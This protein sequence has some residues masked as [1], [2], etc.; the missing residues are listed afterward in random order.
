MERKL[1]HA[2][3]LTWQRDY[4]GATI[5]NAV[6]HA[7]RTGQRIDGDVIGA[8]GESPVH[9]NYSVLMD[10]AWRVQSCVIETYVDGNIRRRILSARGN[11]WFIDG[12]HLPALDG[13]EVIDLGITPSTNTIAINRLSLPIGGAGTVHAAYVDFPSLE[14]SRSHQSYARK[15][16]ARYEYHNLDSGFTAILQVDGSNTV[17]EYGSVWRRLALAE[18]KQVP[19]LTDGRVRQFCTALASENPSTEL[20][21][22][23]SDLDWLVGGW[24]AE[25]RDLQD[26]GS[27]A[28]SSGEWWFSWILEGRALQDVWMVPPPGKRS[29]ALRLN[30]RYGTT[31]R[32]FDSK[33]GRWHIAW[34]NPVSGAH[35]ELSGANVGDRIVLE[36]IADGAPIRWSFVDITAVS[37]RWMGE[38]QTA[39]G[40]RLESEFVLQRLL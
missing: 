10:D 40:W 35:N 24:H 22:H 34:I 1:P 15:D 37:F 2:A 4:R 31:T 20:E 39:D 38:R 9:A 23:A 12:A 18:A 8:I 6:V 19:V 25:V 29:G 28:Q 5:E 26:D 27:V 14:V 16:S 30:N 3:V 21:R 17:V 7:M 11:E 36:G 13:C 33:D 32:R